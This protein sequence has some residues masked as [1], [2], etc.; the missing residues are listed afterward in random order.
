MRA[1]FIATKR[2]PRFHR[3]TLRFG[4]SRVHGRV[5]RC[6]NDFPHS[7]PQPGHVALIELRRFY[8]VVKIHHDGRGPQHPARF[9]IELKRSHDAHRHYGHSELLRHAKNAVVKFADAPGNRPPPLG[10]NDQAHA[11]VQRGARQPPHPLEVGRPRA[12][13]NRHVAKTLHHPAVHRDAKMRLQLQPADELR[14]HAVKHEW[15]EQ[16][17]VVG[18]EEA[19]AASGQNPVKAVLLLARPPTAPGSAKA[20]AAARRCCADR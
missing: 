5:N 2:W 6:G 19:G 9:A 14:N 16:I 11:T 13:R 15:I 17:Y 18:N 10:K 20:S 8:R 4:R 1:A 7:F 3:G 12:F